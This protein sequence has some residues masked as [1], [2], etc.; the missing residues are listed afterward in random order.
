MTLL[1]TVVLLHVMQVVPPDDNGPV[2][3]EFDDNSGE[4]SATDGH[5]AGE[6]A[7]LVN[8]G[9]LT[10]LSGDFETKTRITDKPGVDLFQTSLPAEED[11]VLFLVTALVLIGHGEMFSLRN[12]AGKGSSNAAVENIILSTI[13]FSTVLRLNKQ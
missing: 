5:I 11:G 1:E 6:G 3:L 4:D 9:T 8:V 2:H 12:N 13:I 7:L 10:S